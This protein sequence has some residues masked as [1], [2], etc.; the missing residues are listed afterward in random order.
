MQDRNQLEGTIPSQLG[1][2]EG[3][4]TLSLGKSITSGLSEIFSFAKKDVKNLYGT[5]F[6][7]INAFLQLLHLLH[8]LFEP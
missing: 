7:H 8:L 3:L 5:Y 2:L 1:Q 6:V 4:E